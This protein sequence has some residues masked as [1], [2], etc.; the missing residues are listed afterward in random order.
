M[1]VHQGLK[2]DSTSSEKIAAANSSTSQ[3]PCLSSPSS[4]GK[5]IPSNNLV[6]VK[7]EIPTSDQV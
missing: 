6:T 1:T 3:P 5:E 2:G 4:A 7:K